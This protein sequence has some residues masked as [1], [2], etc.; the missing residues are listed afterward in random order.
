MCFK[1]SI[2][3]YPDYLMDEVGSIYSLKTNK[4]LKPIEHSTGYN[5]IRLSNKSGV[6]TLRYHRVVAKVLVGNPMNYPIVNHKDGNKRNNH[7]SNLEWCTAK[8]NNDHAILTGLKLDGVGVNNPACRYDRDVVRFWLEK[9][10]TGMVKIEDIAKEYNIAR[11]TVTR[12]INI[13]FPE[14]LPKYNGNWRTRVK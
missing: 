6:K 2:P 7:P 8:F 4:V 13:E 10:L 11:T 9:L 14:Q 3:D 5:V 12:L 1:F